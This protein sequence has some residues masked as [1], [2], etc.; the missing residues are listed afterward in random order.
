MIS[1]KAI[2]GTAHYKTEISTGPHLFFADE[3]VD[4]GGTGQGPTPTQLL[5]SSLACCTSI[6]LRMYADRKS[7]AISNI[8]V[9]VMVEKEES[10]GEI[11][12]KRSI[13]LTGTYTP[14]QEQR[15]LQIANAC[16]V[17]KLLGN[18]TKI[19]TGFL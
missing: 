9:N 6:T 1:A 3:P 11:Y 16:P 8:E 15:F 2:T 5:A 10:G 13:K 12:L 4:T 18:Q 19:V 7:I 14:E 17:S